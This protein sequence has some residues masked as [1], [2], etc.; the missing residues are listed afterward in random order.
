M[1]NS[2]KNSLLGQLAEFGFNTDAGDDILDKPNPLAISVNEADIKNSPFVNL[3]NKN[4]AVQ[5]PLNTAASGKSYDN[6]DG[7]ETYSALS[8]EN[9]Q[10]NK[11]QNNDSAPKRIIQ[12]RLNDF[13]FNILQDSAFVNIEDSE[14]SDDEK[15]SKVTNLIKEIDRKLFLIKERDNSKLK[16]KLLSDR[17][18]LS[19]VLSRLN[20]N[21]NQG[22]AAINTELKEAIN[23]STFAFLR[24][25]RQI[26]PDDKN[27]EGIPCKTLHKFLHKYFP[28]LYKGFLVKQALNKLKA[29]NQTAGELLAKRIPYGESSQRYDALIE[30]LSSANTIHAKLIKKI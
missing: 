12:K 17:E 28:K 2:F 23:G 9:S 21:K 26:L 13:D 4:P 5:N 27:F 24:K 10:T 29:L 7:S 6:T 14:L 30:Y 18:M 19:S 3:D 20:S 1:E 15:V 25:I 16:E 8:Q 11:L 22:L